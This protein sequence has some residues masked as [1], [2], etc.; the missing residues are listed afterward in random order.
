[1]SSTGSGRKSFSE[2]LYKSLL[3]FY[4]AQVRRQFSDDM[5]ELYRDLCEAERRKRGKRGVVFLSLRAY[6]DVLLGAA[7]AH[8]DH[9]RKSRGKG[10]S[11]VIW[12]KETFLLRGL[13]ADTVSTFRMMVSRPGF[14]VAVILTLAVGIGATTAMFGTL[15]A[16]LLCSLP[17]DEPDRLVLGR[18]TAD[19]ELKPMVSGYDYYDYRDQSQSFESLAA[20]L[21]WRSR[22]TVLGGAEPERIL[23]GFVTWDLFHT[24]RV[25]PALGRPFTADEGVEGGPNVV[26]ISD[27]YWHRRFGGSSEAVGSILQMD[28]SPFT[29]LGVMPAGF[30]FYHDYDVWRLTYYNGMGADAR[31]WHNLF[32]VG[33]LKPGTT[34]EEAQ[35]EVDVISRRLEQ[36]YPD[37]NEGKG[38]LLTELHDA[39][40]EDLSTTMAMLMAAV[41]LLLLLSCGNVA[42]LLLA[43]GQNRLKEIAIR[44]AMGAS[45]RRLVRQLLTESTLT[46]LLAG[47]AG[48]VFAIAFQGLLIRLLPMGQLGI[49]RLDINLPVLLFA[50]GVSIAT[51]IVFGVV[52]ALQ[53]TII[54]PS[55]E[56]RA[57]TRASSARSASAA[58]S[59]FIVLQV[60]IATVLLIGAGLLVRSLSL[61]MKVEL[62]FNPTHLYTAE[63]SLPEDA[64]PEPDQRIAFFTSM[65]EEV[66]ALPGVVSV[67]LIN[68]LPIRDVSGS[69]Y[70]HRDQNSEE[71]KELALLRCALPGYLKTMGIP[72][73]A[74]R[75]ISETD[76]EGAPRVMIVSESMAEHYF[77]DQNPLGKKLL[78]DMGEMVA[79][80]IIGIAGDARLNRIT[81]GPNHTMYMSYFQ[82][83]REVMRIA[84]RTAADTSSVAR[85][86]Q[87]ILRTKDANLLLAEPVTMAS[88]LD[89]ALSDFRITTSA[90][91]LFS[92]IALLLALVGLYGVLAYNV[93][94][95]YHEIGVRMA[96]GAGRRHVAM[97][98]LSRGMG[99]V[100]AGLVFG[101]VAAYWT[102][103]L[104]QGLLFRVA[105]NDPTTFILAALSFGA[106][107]VMACLLP[108]WRATRVDPVTVIQSE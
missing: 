66:E 67:G 107:A 95:R 72:L 2:R 108:A 56:L 85:P 97:M 88:V 26:L 76:A 106:T 36:R 79:H 25:S 70:V 39:M 78:V 12:I 41:S 20:F 22:F 11:A 14:T 42:A 87:E 61:Q 35:S 52:P 103:Q 45:R 6:A 65:V 81:S 93:S 18:R 49:T 3:T 38:L 60:A 89:D 43:R 64:Y 84:V 98:I 37:T 50:F 4:P 86:I 30:H 101:M 59:G 24:L 99:M 62:G 57:G 21:P 102:T 40:V 10:R 80:E 55:C 74:G 53:G 33:R 28:G 32:V 75:D 5:L 100:A 71:S 104:I 68:R 31:R 7:L 48:V 63:L 91:G 27:S 51:G 13:F 94:Q 54:E 44:T 29:V 73:L 17:F 105:P 77:P 9:R 69:V 23:C 16:A 90:L 8:R 58:R 46:A 47:V 96:L 15:H 1:M 82:N 83:P 92:S 34:L 19:G